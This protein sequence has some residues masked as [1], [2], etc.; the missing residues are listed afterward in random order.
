[1]LLGV[2]EHLGV[3]VPLGVLR[4]GAEPALQ[5]CFRCRS[6]KK[7]PVPLTGRGDPVSLWSWAC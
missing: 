4:L 2:S 1:M 5:V 7:E 3:R 6:N